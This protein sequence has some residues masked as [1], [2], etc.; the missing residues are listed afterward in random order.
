M[1]KIKMVIFDLAGTTIR[2]DNG[3]RDCL[4]QAAAEFKLQTTPDEIQLHMGT[5]KI[6]LY[7]FL[8][9]KARGADVNFRDFEKVQSPE[10]LETATQIFHR[11]EEIMLAYY[12]REVTEIPGAADTFRW[13]HDH[14]IKVATGTGFHRQITEAIMDGLGWLRDG[15]VDISVDV[16]HTPQQ[17]GRP[18][19]FMIFHAMT[20]LDIQ[21]VN[22]VVKVGDTPADMLEGANA[23][24]RGIVGV[25]S[26]PL[27]V[28]AWG[29]YRH[30]HVISS[31]KVLPQLIETEFA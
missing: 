24:C 16:E 29:G 27:P 25:L 9:A 14:G 21:S 19:P 7:Q 5:N 17:R 3:V 18:A 22:E 30:T 26:G 13:C 6:H 8:I 15:L 10:T 4:H 28:T 20:Q 2:D 11:Y 23:G 1:S 12:R 31:V